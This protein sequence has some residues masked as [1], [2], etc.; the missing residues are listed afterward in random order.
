MMTLMVF[1]IVVMNYIVMINISRD[2]EDK[3]TSRY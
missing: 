1:A 2:D 3:L